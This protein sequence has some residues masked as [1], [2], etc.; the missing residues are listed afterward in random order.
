MTPQQ[1]IEI[2]KC[3]RSPIYFINNYIYFYDTQERK[4]ID[5]K[6]WDF[7]ED[8]VND[9]SSN[10]FHLILKSRQLGITTINL[11][12]ALYDSVFHKNV[13]IL[14]IAQTET[15]AQALLDNIKYMFENL[16][17]WMKPEVGK[18]SASHLEF[19]NLNSSIEVK[20]CSPKAGRSIQATTVILD[21]YAFYT[22]GRSKTLD[23]DLYTSIYPTV[24]RKGRLIVIS[25]PNGFGNHFHHLVT[26][27]RAKQLNNFSFHLLDWKVR[28]D[29]DEA[30]YKDTLQ[31]LGKKKFSQ[32]YECSFLQSGTPVFSQDYLS[33]KGKHKPPE[34]SKKYV[35]GADPSE[36]SEDGDFSAAYVLDIETMEEVAAVRG[37]YKP[38]D[39]A[40]I[41]NTLGRRYNNALLGVERNNHGHTVLLRLQ[42]L[43]YPNLY[44]H[45]DGKPGFLT[46][47]ATKPVMIDELEEALR[48]N[49]LLIASLDLYD[50]LLAYQYDQKGSTNAPTG[51][52]DDTVM[53]MAI[54]YQMRKASNRGSKGHSKKPNGW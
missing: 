50:E 5:L 23:I 20:A 1:V 10:R 36:G 19:V 49:L 33:I 9:L 14:I 40:E 27:S 44:T 47:S 45:T 15:D 25:T 31:A 34:Q 6:L 41:L 22:Q 53:A 52:H 43:A 11:A 29:R 4:K 32:E 7:Q 2:K 46:S 13:R 38:A 18:D 30:W 28:K 8:F 26:Q 35:I 51:F 42:Q 54:S 48:L 21:E 39:F 16:P 17:D 37:R 3:H 24:A 12:Y